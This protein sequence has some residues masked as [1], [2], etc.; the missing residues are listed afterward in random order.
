MNPENISFSPDWVSKPGETI[1]AALEERNLAP[2]VF[3]QRLGRAPEFADALLD[4]EVEITIKIAQKLVAI[5]GGSTAFWMTREAQYRCGLA[6]LRPASKEKTDTEWLTELPLKEMRSFGWLS[7]YAGVVN[8]FKTCLNFFGVQTVSDWH[9]TY[10]Q[11]LNASAF[12]KSVAFK[13]EFG[14]TA[15]WLRQGEL[16]AGAITTKAWSASRFETALHKVRPL[17]RRKDPGHFIMELQKICA[18]SGVAVVV[19][20]APAGCRAS[21]A[22]RFLSPTKACLILSFRYLSDD[23]FWF[24]FFHE[25]GHLMLHSKDLVFLE[26]GDSI[27][28]E[29]EREANE[30]AAELLIPKSERSNL[31]QLSCNSTEVIR[32]AHKLGISPGIVV[33]QMQ[34]R[35][36]ISPRYL[37]G[38]KRRFVWGGINLEKQ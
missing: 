31:E 34:H 1:A 17:T 23:H 36:I 38:L 9:K 22:T 29:Q 19:L 28:A 12:K 15:A 16:E 4:G 14:A 10:G 37:N 33:G 21:G 27:S 32:F 13:T 26:D 7:P 24:T 30:Y 5:V 11:V 25:A 6:R 8:E 35:G 3:A 20:R 18:E 2:T